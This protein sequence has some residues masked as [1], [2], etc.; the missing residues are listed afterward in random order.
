MTNF[1]YPFCSSLV[2]DLILVHLCLN[3][4]ASRWQHQ[5]GKWRLMRLKRLAGVVCDIRQDS[6]LEMWVKACA[7]DIAQQTVLT[8]WLSLLPFHP[9]PDRNTFAFS[10]FLAYEQKCHQVER[11]HAL[12]KAVQARL[13]NAL[14]CLWVPDTFTSAE[15]WE[16]RAESRGVD[17]A[18]KY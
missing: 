13:R 16:R 9:T 11:H 1:I 15:G 5:S 17:E 4:E 6:F 12:T 10:P 7:P 14:L 2:L 18:S 3:N 8:N